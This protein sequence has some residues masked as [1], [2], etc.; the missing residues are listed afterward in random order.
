MLLLC[1]CCFSVCESEYVRV[2]CICVLRVECSVCVREFVFVV[3]MMKYTQAR[4][5][6]V[7]YVLCMCQS[8]SSVV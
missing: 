4:A 6:G 5:G 7:V 8:S 3:C 1:V 2:P